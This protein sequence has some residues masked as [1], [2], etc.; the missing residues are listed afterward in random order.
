MGETAAASAL[1]SMFHDRLPRIV[2]E[3][4]AGLADRH[5]LKATLS[6]VH[7]LKGNAGNLSADRLYRVASLLES[8]LRR[9]D[10][11]DVPLLLK[12]LQREAEALRCAIPAVLDTL[13]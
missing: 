6:K 7:T 11:A 4:S 13:A 2:A 9:E 1:L 12:D 3:I 8:A 5:G 10:I